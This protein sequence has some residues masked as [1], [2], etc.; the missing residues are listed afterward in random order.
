MNALAV[1]RT[2][3]S[4]AEDADPYGVGRPRRAARR[5]LAR[6]VRS[7]SI[8]GPGVKGPSRSRRPPAHSFPI[9]ESRLEIVRQTPP[10]VSRAAELHDRLVESGQT[11]PASDL[12]TFLLVIESDT[13]DLDAACKGEIAFRSARIS[14]LWVAET[15]RGEG[16]GSALLE[17]AEKLAME[18]GCDRIHLET[19]SEAARRLY[20]R[21]GYRVFGELPNY[22]GAQSFYY[23][24]KSLA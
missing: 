11:L 16:L 17:E 8:A 5:R 24:E 7:R 9:V 3:S 23:L 1:V 12:S 6:V 18:N 2:S 10:T 19:R 20:E 15:R 4:I 13:G 14:E 22:E 21:T